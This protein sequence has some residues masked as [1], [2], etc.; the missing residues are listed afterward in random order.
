MALQGVEMTPWI[1]GVNVVPIFTAP[2][3][4]GL[5]VV[6]G[7]AQYPLPACANSLVTPPAEAGPMENPMKSPCAMDTFASCVVTTSSTDAGRVIGP[8][9]GVLPGLLRNPA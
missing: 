2:P 8:G 4:N 5:I 7:F 6:G 9:V 1:S 3:G